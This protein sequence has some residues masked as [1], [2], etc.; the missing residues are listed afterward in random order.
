[1][2]ARVHAI[3]VARQGND[4]RAQLL[5]TLEALRRQTVPPVAVTVVVTGSADALR[6]IDTFDGLVEGVIQARQGTSAAE[7]FAIAQPRV[8]DGSAVWML[9]QDTAPADDA[10]SHL[11]GALERSPSALIAAP[12]LVRP[13]NDREIVSLG[14]SMSRYGRTVELAADELDQGQHDGVEDVLAADIR[15]MLIRSSARPHLRPD[16]AL[17]GADEGLD[18]GVRARLG[19]GR[20]ALVPQARVS[21]SV[22]GPLALPRRAVSRAWAVRRA[23]LHRRLSYAPALA[24]PL[25]WLSLL[26]LALWRTMTHLVGKRPADV[27]PEWGTALAAMVRL[28]SVARSRATIRAFRHASWSS[29]TPLRV[30]RDQL[31]QRLDDGQ[32]SEGGA[33][34]ELNFFSGGAAWAVLAAFVVGLTAL[35]PLLAWPVLGG[36]D[37]FRFTRAWARCGGMPRGGCGISG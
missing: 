21:A 35:T 15:G 31:R 6:D 10:L 34:G 19:G 12:K 18:L 11:A 26:P 5:H 13:N 29:I 9:A 14:V 4:A 23:Q 22:D 28:P 3:I 32:G 1:M 2:P 20:V 8:D 37:S 30:S 7:A 17:G 25:H 24:V 16:P 27:A 36:G 33:V